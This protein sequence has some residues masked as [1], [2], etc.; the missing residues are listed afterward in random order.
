MT[1]DCK[2]KAGHTYCPKCGRAVPDICEAKVVGEAVV[3][4]ETPPELA[5]APVVD[6]PKAL[7]PIEKARIAKAAKAAARKETQ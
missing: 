3:P 6:E 1:Y 4:R 2:I 7:T 5:A